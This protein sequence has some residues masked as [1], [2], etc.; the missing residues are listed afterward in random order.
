MD[1]ILTPNCGACTVHHTPFCP[2][3]SEHLK[4][5][6]DHMIVEE[7]EGLC[8]PSEIDINGKRVWEHIGELLRVRRAQHNGGAAGLPPSYA[9]GNT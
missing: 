1:S 4:H 7:L 9:G 8:L 5:E 2:A 3:C 6:I